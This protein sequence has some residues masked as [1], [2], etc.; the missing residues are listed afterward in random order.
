MS[1][2]T[3]TLHQ[4]LQKHEKAIIIAELKQG[5]MMYQ[6]AEELGI[7]YCTLWRKMRQHGISE[8]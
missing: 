5:R 4:Q 1:H 8:A 7:R 6:T 2:Q 3:Q